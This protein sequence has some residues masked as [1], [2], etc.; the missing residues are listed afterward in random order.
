MLTWALRCL[1]HAFG[2]AVFTVLW[3]SRYL[4]YSY[5]SARGFWIIVPVTTFNFFVL[6]LGSLLELFDSVLCH[7][8]GMRLC[9]ALE[10]NST[11]NWEHSTCS[12]PTTEWRWG[13]EKKTRVFFS[14][15]FLD[16]WA[17]PSITLS[18]QWYFRAPGDL[19][20][21]SSHGFNSCQAGELYCWWI[22]VVNQATT[23]LTSCS[24]MQLPNLQGK[25]LAAI[26]PPVMAGLNICFCGKKADGNE[27]L[28][29]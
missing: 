29:C 9:T 18:T 19:A 12:Q 10:Q 21:V 13:R 25:V 23:R 11:R 2:M 24:E 8:L 22:L 1:E 6:E 4:M 27:E 7:R 20:N 15:C 26:L 5:L 28:W 14:V 17:Y 3:R 16:F